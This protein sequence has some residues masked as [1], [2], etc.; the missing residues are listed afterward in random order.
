MYLTAIWSSK[1][2]ERVLSMKMEKSHTSPVK[3]GLG[4]SVQVTWR[5]YWHPMAI[6]SSRNRTAMLCS[7]NKNMG[8]SYK[9]AGYQGY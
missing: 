9:T 7:R 5:I 6:T 1:L 2:Q 4:V 8:P 3:Q